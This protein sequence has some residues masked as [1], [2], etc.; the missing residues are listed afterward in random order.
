MPLVCTPH[1][2]L[3]NTKFDLP[4]LWMKTY[5]HQNVYMSMNEGTS[6]G[7][8]R[9][10]GVISLVCTV[11]VQFF[12][13][14]QTACTGRAE[15]NAALSAKANKGSECA[16]VHTFVLL[17]IRVCPSVIQSV[18]C[19]FNRCAI[20]KY[21]FLFVSL[22]LCQHTPYILD[23][24]HIIQYNDTL[25]PHHVSFCFSSVRKYLWMCLC[26]TRND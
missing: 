4:S 10:G 21:R 26:H 14:Q 23:I 17:C 9:V 16:C 5:I 8:Q 1:I 15:G 6:N 20:H 18:L 24:T 13:W 22:R 2:F 19:A 3:I 12:P 7:C 25:F 11:L